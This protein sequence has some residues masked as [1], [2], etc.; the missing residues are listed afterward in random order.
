MSSRPMP[1]TTNPASF[2]ACVDDSAEDIP[3]TPIMYRPRSDTILTTSSAS[4]SS[5]PQLQTPQTPSIL[6]VLDSFNRHRSDSY[7]FSEFGKALFQDDPRGEELSQHQS[8]TEPNIER[9]GGLLQPRGAVEDREGVLSVPP[10]ENAITWPT[11]HEDPMGI[12]STGAPPASESI[13]ESQGKGKQRARSKVR[14]KLQRSK[15]SLKDL[16][17]LHSSNHPLED[18]LAVAF[19]PGNQETDVSRPRPRLRSLLSMSRAGSRA[20]STTSIR[21]LGALASD[22]AVRTSSTSIMLNT[23][24]TVESGSRVAEQDHLSTGNANLYQPVPSTTAATPGA[25]QL[26]TGTLQDGLLIAPSHSRR[27]TRPAPVS[28]L[29]TGRVMSYTPLAPPITRSATDPVLARGTFE[30]ATRHDDPKRDLFATILPR[31]LK[32]MVMRAVLDTGSQQERSARWGGEVGARKELIRLS[33][34]SPSDGIPVHS[35]AAH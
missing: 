23:T 3:S 31:E 26:K 27:C 25:K 22:G 30:M 9:V 5:S 24:T 7:G 12:P 21:T 19:R 16:L 20:S 32:V 29:S 15:S 2:R 4:S 11:H 1:M 28:A 8:E 10:V 33:R 34:V 6:G 18:Q 17:G 13:E 14:T 35:V